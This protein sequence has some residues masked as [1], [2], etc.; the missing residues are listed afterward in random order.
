LAGQSQEPLDYLD[1]RVVLTG[2]RVDLGQIL[3][4]D[5]AAPGLALNGQQ[6][7]GAAAGAPGFVEVVRPR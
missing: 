7:D 6:L 3:E 1:R 2:P 5:D 4:E